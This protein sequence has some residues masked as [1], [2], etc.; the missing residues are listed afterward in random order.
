MPP[1]RSSTSPSPPA[2]AI[3][4]TLR[5]CT[6]CCLATCRGRSPNQASK[7]RSKRGDVVGAGAQGEP[8]GPVDLLVLR[9][10]ERLDRPDRRLHPVGRRRDAGVAQRPAQ[11]DQAV[12]DVVGADSASVTTGERAVE[13]LAD[14]DLGAVLVLA[15]LEHRAERRAGEVGVEPLRPERQQRLGPVDRLR[16]AGRLEQV[17]LAERADGLGDVAGQRLDASGTRG[18]DDGDLAL[19]LGVLDPVVEAAPLQRVVHLAGAVAGDDDDRR[20]LGADRAE[21]GDRDREVA[22]HLQQEGLELVVGAVDLVDEQHARRGLQGGQQGSGQQEAAVVDLGLQLVDP[23]A[24]PRG[25]GR[26][27]VQQL[28]GKSQS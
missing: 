24:G 21:L 4:W 6:R 13:H 5:S 12:G 25:L 28:A 18:P 19:E 15:V 23:A 17:L 1:S 9:P 22:Q 14:V 10:V 2:S 16:D 11:P 27:Q 20:D 26:P 7:T 3:V 8:A